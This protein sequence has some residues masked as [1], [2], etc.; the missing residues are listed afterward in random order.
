MS[1][2]FAVL[3]AAGTGSPEQAFGQYRAILDRPE[4]TAPL[5]VV[6]I[7]VAQLRRRS[8]PLTVVQPPDGRGLLLRAE[9]GDPLTDLCAALRL[10]ATR[11]LAV[12]EVDARRLHHPRTAA[13]VAVTAGPHTFPIVSEPLVELLIPDSRT[14]DDPPVI[15]AHHRDVQLRIRQLPDNILELTHQSGTQHFRL[16]TDDAPIARKVTCSWARR[17]AWWQEAISW[18]PCD[19]P[20]DH[21]A[22]TDDAA[23]LLAELEE[24]RAEVDDLEALDAGAAV[25]HL[26]ALTQSVLDIDIPDF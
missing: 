8:T 26:D 21:A 22:V 1:S 20:G 3:P 6:G 12:F 14:V 9:S 17:D 16:L 5:P 13:R 4:S 24:L 23:A 11:D 19:P 25:N 10:T 18:Q 15:L 7:V 2:V